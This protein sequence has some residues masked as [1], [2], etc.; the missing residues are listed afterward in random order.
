MSGSAFQPRLMG[1]SNAKT[2]GTDEKDLARTK[3][4][5]YTGAHYSM[6]MADQIGATDKTAKHRFDNEAFNLVTA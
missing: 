1:D 2:Y 4:V 3:F 5:E 6:F